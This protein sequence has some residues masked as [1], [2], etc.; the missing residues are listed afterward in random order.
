MQLC[1]VTHGGHGAAL[2]WE[3]EQPVSAAIKDTTRSADPEL[4]FTT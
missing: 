3:V 4:M 2:D 1:G